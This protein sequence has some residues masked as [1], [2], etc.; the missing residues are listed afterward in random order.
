MGSLLKKIVYMG[1]GI[2]LLSSCKKDD[3][4]P[5]ASYDDVTADASSMTVEGVSLSDVTSV[6]INYGSGKTI[7][8]TNIGFNTDPDATI[9]LDS[10][11]FSSATSTVEAQ[12]NEY[13][14]MKNLK[15]SINLVIQFSHPDK[16]GMNSLTIRNITQESAWA[17][18]TITNNLIAPGNLSDA[19]TFFINKNTAV[20][21]ATYTISQ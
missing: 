17:G 11:D 6:T 10:K 7:T 20:A 5:A 12:N 19:E 16:V 1:L 2:G 13:V 15:T 21:K 18:Q 14:L 9:T 4:P 8:L 3:A